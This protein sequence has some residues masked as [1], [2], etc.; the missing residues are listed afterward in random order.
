MSFA[1]VNCSLTAGLTARAGPT[2]A[3]RSLKVSAVQGGAA[4]GGE[5]VWLP[6]VERPSHL[7]GVDLPGNRGFDPLNLAI[8]HDRLPWSVPQLQLQLHGRIKIPKAAGIQASSPCAGLQRA[9]RPT[10]DGL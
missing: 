4:Q 6:G 2:R 10:V 1:L 5:P 3:R 9:R 8:D 7:Q